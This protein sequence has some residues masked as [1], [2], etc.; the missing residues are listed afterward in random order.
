[1]T[2]R[3]APKTLRVVC[4]RRFLTD[5]EEEGA[6]D[7]WAPP[8]PGGD[9]DPRHPP[10]TPT[11]AAPL[12]GHR[13]ETTSQ[14]PCLGTCQ[15]APHHA[16]SAWARGAGVRGW[17]R[18]DRGPTPAPPLKEPR[19]GGPALLTLPFH[20]SLGRVSGAFACVPLPVPLAHEGGGSA[21]EDACKGPG[22]VRSSSARTEAAAPPLR[23]THPQQ[24]YFD[25][26]IWDLGAASLRIADSHPLPRDPG[27]PRPPPARPARRGWWHPGL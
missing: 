3:L 1:M 15:A 2:P 25:R 8:V 7:P 22:R 26:R 6:G 19:L 17:R 9:S 16:R 23:R 13:R 4:T 21:G 10:P 20:L 11:T 24:F 5:Q 12:P 27:Q 18:A 14:R